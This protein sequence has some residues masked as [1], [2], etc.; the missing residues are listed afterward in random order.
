VHPIIQN[1]SDFPL[2]L[3]S[4]I[5]GSHR[6]VKDVTKIESGKKQRFVLKR[7]DD[8]RSLYKRCETGLE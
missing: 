3:L 1:F 2:S 4:W 7:G 8:G 5:L 6:L